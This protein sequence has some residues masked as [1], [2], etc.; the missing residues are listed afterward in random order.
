MITLQPGDPA[1]RFSLRD[2]RGDI[3]TL[4]DHH[5]RKVLVYFYPQADT[6]GCT[7]QSCA[8]RDAKAD[9]ARLGIDIMGISPD[10]PEEQAA[11]DEKFA[12]GF[13]LLS[14]PDHAVADVYGAWGEKSKEGRTYRG[15]VRASFLIDEDGLIEEAWYRVLPEDTVPNV[16]AALVQPI[17]RSL[18]VRCAPDRAFRLFTEGIGTWW[19]LQTHSRAEDDFHG[20]GVT[21]ERVEFPTGPGQPI[22]EHFSNGNALPWGDVLAYEPPTRVVIAWKPNANPNPPTEIEVRFAADGERTRVDLEH[23]GWERLG[24]I[25]PTAREPYASPDGWTRV[26]SLFGT[27]TDAA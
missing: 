12:L 19:P 1:P 4:A 17:H 7:T 27:A 22:V 9:L 3:V 14:D 5:G 20:R 6:P 15:I 25:G 16:I 13:P 11:F 24:E 21:T 8:V 10:E 2:Q 23:R 26:L 18:S